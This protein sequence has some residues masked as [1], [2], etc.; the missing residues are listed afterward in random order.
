MS[1]FLSDRKGQADG[2]TQKGM[3][4][5]WQ[6]PGGWAHE[7]RNAEDSQ[8]HRKLRERCGDTLPPRAS[9]AR[10]GPL[11]FRLL[12]SGTRR[13]HLPLVFNCP[14]CRNRL[15]WPQA[16]ECR[17]M[18]TCRTDLSSLEDQGGLQGGGDSRTERENAKECAG[19][20]KRKDRL[21]AERTARALGLWPPGSLRGG[22][23]WRR[24]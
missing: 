2:H 14:A 22:V 13:E 1:V 7:P 4:L 24:G 18:S 11:D 6:R 16:H 8:R 21:R 19:Q 17:Y 12:A 23:L 15:R 10:R 5:W 20:T 3:G 9:L